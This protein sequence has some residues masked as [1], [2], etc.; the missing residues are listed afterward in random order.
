MR[1]WS[2]TI[3]NIAPYVPGE[4]PRDKKYIKLN[5]NE[6]PYPP[7][8]KVLRAIESE[9]SAD[10]RLYP[11]PDAFR[12]KEAIAS[13]YD[14]KPSEVFT[15]N[16]SDEVLAFCFPAF[17]DPDDRIAFPEITYSFYPVY[18]NLFRIPYQTVPMG[19]DFS[20][21]FEGFQE[22]LKGIILANPNAPT[23][24]DAGLEQIQALLKRYPNTL[25]IV[26]EAYVDFGSQSA[27]PLISQYDN[28]LV[29]HTFSK[30][31]SLAG[32]RVG[33]AIGNA[34]L[35]DGLEQVKNS[36][37]SYTLDRVAQK[38]AIA[39]VN[40]TEYSREISQ[41]IIKTRDTVTRKLIGMGFKV[42]PSKTNFLFISHEKFAGRELFLGLKREGILVRHFLKP[43]IE[44]WLRVT[45]GTDNEMEIFVEK[46]K[47]MMI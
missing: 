10:V 43:G 19:A 42:L 35:V 23:S 28:L 47:T 5:T 25:L 37:N 30:F 4:Q 21:Q 1:F 9:I 16:G 41:R 15:G 39:A 27:I 45:I 14:V 44:N 46:L 18:A 17:F 33:Y 24:I 32:L 31:R 13:F 26:D 2:K 7:S 36:F 3:R 40:D 11:D 8:P 34:C 38:A 22:G 20:V 29:I 12:L 6:N